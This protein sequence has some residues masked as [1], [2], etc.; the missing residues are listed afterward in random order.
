M[1]VLAKNR[2]R[3]YLYE[4]E[5][6]MN[7]T[8]EL[9][10]DSRVMLAEFLNKLTDLK[11]A[12]T[13]EEEIAELKTQIERYLLDPS[14]YKKKRWQHDSRLSVAP[15][16]DQIQIKAIEDYLFK[17]VLRKNTLSDGEIITF[18]KKAFAETL[19]EYRSRVDKEEF[20]EWGRGVVRKSKF[21]K[22]VDQEC[23]R[24]IEALTL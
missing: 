3:I 7:P 2:K 11:N 6:A 10:D 17:R 5:E 19:K 4:A 22:D 16:E 8:D 14:A 20:I 21:F 13:D 12:C 18:G 1:S 23:L 24:I 9:V 15:T